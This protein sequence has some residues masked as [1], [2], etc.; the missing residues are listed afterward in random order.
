[1]SIT[2]SIWSS[3]LLPDLQQL[4]TNQKQKNLTT[5][6]PYLQKQS[7]NQKKSSLPKKTQTQAFQMATKLMSFLPP[8]T[9]TLC[10]KSQPPPPP[11]LPW[12]LGTHSLPHSLEYSEFSQPINQP[13]LQQTKPWSSS[14]QKQS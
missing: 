3:F 8:K 4:T 9:H 7:H 2:V 12:S 10:A 11:P 6:N 5:Q 1:M 13:L 14:K